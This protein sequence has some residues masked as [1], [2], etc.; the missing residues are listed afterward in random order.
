MR[1]AEL[2]G[3]PCAE[4]R[5][6]ARERSVGQ[7]PGGS[8]GPG[9]ALE[10]ELRPAEGTRHAKSYRRSP[11]PGPDIAATSG[12]PG[13]LDSSQDQTMTD[14]LLLLDEAPWPPR[15]GSAAVYRL[16]IE[17]LRKRGLT[18]AVG[19]VARTDR[20]WLPASSRWCEQR[21]IPWF[22]F[23]SVT[24]GGPTETTLRMGRGLLRQPTRWP[25]VLIDDQRNARHLARFAPNMMIV[26]KVPTA[27]YFGVRSIRTFSGKKALDLH[28][29]F[30]AR[31]KETRR[32]LANSQAIAGRNYGT[33]RTILEC[34]RYPGRKLFDVYAR[35]EEG[36]VINSFDRLLIASTAEYQYYLQRSD[37]RVEIEFFPWP[38]LAFRGSNNTASQQ[39][40]QSEFDIGFIA[41]DERFNIDAANHLIHDLLPKLHSS[42]VGART[43]ICGSVVDA[44]DRSD[45]HVPVTFVK[46]AENI[47]EF[48]SRIRLAVVPLK[49]GTGVSIKTL[50]AL[51]FH[52]PVLGTP[53]GLRG[54]T[55][56]LRRF[57]VEFSSPD[58]FVEAVRSQQVRSGTDSSLSAALERDLR[59]F[60]RRMNDLVE[61]C[62][63]RTTKAGHVAARPC[64]TG[65]RKF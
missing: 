32:S 45:I 47:E 64:N 17:A 48:Y 16:S 23:D 62:V 31:H 10:R 8:H 5:P 13:K 43:L 56:E 24:A 11:D 2:R 20:P 42:G 21:E 25:N 51:A 33:S 59:E 14:A 6:A 44:L 29:D 38:A 65:S 60:E 19:C 46:H 1:Q 28:D 49:A 26:H 9:A 15:T 34:A 55:P 36:C 61:D 27:I 4:D 57:T 41:S 39:I 40:S 18:V 50:E 30:P 12:H 3:E 53:I 63:L 7:A 37:L 52:R 22:V 54:L 35:A 58:E